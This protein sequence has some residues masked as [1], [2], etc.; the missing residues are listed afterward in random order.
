MKLPPHDISFRSVKNGTST[1]RLYFN[2]VYLFM[3][4]DIISIPE[5]WDT[6]DANTIYRGRNTVKTFRFHNLNIAVKRYQKLSWV[7]RFVYTHMRPTKAIRGLVYSLEYI[8]R[9]IPSPEGIA[10]IEIYRRGILSDT[11]LI[12]ILSAGHELFPELVMARNYDPQ[13][14]IN[15]ADFI[16][17]MH[18][19]GII[20][21]D[22]NLRNILSGNPD[23][24]GNRLFE[25][26]DINRSVFTDSRFSYS[27]IATNLSR[28]TH[29]REL[30]QLITERYA[31][32]AGLDVNRLINDV[33]NRLNDFERGK[34][35]RH[36]FK[37]ILFK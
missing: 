29:R 36:R 23:E 7:R 5:R 19:C 16:F 27:R 20:N 32:N 9:G 37:Q 3:L 33:I 8:R 1:L 18:Q 31:V 30:L 10:A 28:V 24:H 2:P 13:L 4:D 15:V 11:Y 17:R 21:K 22:S 26:I 34:S 25:C 6:G 14:A 12:T 35:I